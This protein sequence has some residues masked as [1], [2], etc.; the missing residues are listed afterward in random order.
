MSADVRRGARVPDLKAQRVTFAAIYWL[1]M[2][3]KIYLYV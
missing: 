1:K 3:G 2:K